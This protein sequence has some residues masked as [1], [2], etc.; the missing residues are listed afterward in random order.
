MKFNCTKYKG[1]MNP[2]TLYEIQ[3]SN[4]IQFVEKQKGIAEDFINVSFKLEG[5]QYGMFANEYRPGFIADSKKVD[6]LLLII[7]ETKKICSS[8]ILDIKVSVGG[9]DV[10]R[11]LIEQWQASY[12]HKCTLTNYLDGFMETEI[13]G[14]ITRNYQEDRIK[15]YVENKKNSIEKLTQILDAMPN[16]ALKMDQQRRLLNL[17][18]E[19]SMYEKFQKGYVTI[20]GKDYP[21]TIYR[22]EGDKV[23]YSCDM[24]IQC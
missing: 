24:E 12:Q 11:H 7:D 20:L 9:E 5:N 6:I 2:N 13:V 18:L 17:K 21:I 19:Y 16:S 10:I 15:T 1:K 3:Q 4:I 22:L 8:W 14:V 23:P